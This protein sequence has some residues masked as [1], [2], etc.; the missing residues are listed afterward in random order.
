MKKQYSRRLLNLILSCDSLEGL[1]D[2]GLLYKLTIHESRNKLFCVI[3][4]IIYIHAA[5]EERPKP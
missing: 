5:T 2:Y 3:K 4:G 1:R